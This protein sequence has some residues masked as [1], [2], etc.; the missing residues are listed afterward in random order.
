MPFY[1]LFEINQMPHVGM[2]LLTVK[3]MRKI[4][5][6]IVYYTGSKTIGEH[7]GTA[8]HAQRSVI[9]LATIQNA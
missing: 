7:S 4:I 1:R 9:D 2:S 6:L 3:I 8:T 5:S